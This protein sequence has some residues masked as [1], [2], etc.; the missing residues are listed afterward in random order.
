MSWCAR[1]FWPMP[2][3]AKG[4]SSSSPLVQTLALEVIADV[5]SSFPSLQR[6]QPSFT[7]ARR[8]EATRLLE[9]QDVSA[10]PS[11]RLRLPEVGMP[12]IA[13]LDLE[14]SFSPRMIVAAPRLT[15]LCEF[16][17]EQLEAEYKCD[18]CRHES[19]LRTAKIAVATALLNTGAVVLNLVAGAE[20]S[21]EL[22]AWYGLA[23]GFV[24]LSYAGSLLPRSDEYLGSNLLPM[25]QLFIAS[26]AAAYAVLDVRQ[27]AVIAGAGTLGVALNTGL[28]L[29][30]KVPSCSNIEHFEVIKHL[31]NLV[32]L[33]VLEVVMVVGSIRINTTMRTAYHFQRVIKDDASL[34]E[35]AVAERER[36]LQHEAE[37]ELKLRTAEAAKAAR[38]SLIRM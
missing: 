21:A 8:S 1:W 19:T 35:V 23:Y 26:L 10:T 4:P 33:A 29:V 22:I 3:A 18:E 31:T 25:H 11:R 16:E 6:S 30:R 5:T 14:A 37:V 2:A 9:H 36:M 27:V 34:R 12:F 24:W 15:R 20:E 28:E 17:D 13:P 7:I 32:G 38:G